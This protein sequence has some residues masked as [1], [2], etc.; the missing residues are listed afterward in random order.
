[1]RGILGKNL[2]LAVDHMDVAVTESGALD[3]DENLTGGRRGRRHVFE[4][5]FVPVVVES[6]SFHSSSP[7]N[8]RRSLDSREGGARRFYLQAARRP[9][10]SWKIP[11]IGVCVL[12]QHPGVD[13]CSEHTSARDLVE[14][15][16]RLRSIQRQR[17]GRLLEIVGLD[18]RDEVF[19]RSRVA[20]IASSSGK[21]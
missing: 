3:A 19:T 1:M 2:D 12:G 10:E 11:T 16:S 4:N 7:G 17:Q 20:V 9:G 15:E 6:R 5:Q 21:S 8:N 14:T 13:Q 18:S